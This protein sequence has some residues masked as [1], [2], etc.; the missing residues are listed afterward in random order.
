MGRDIVSQDAIAEPLNVYGLTI[1]RDRN[2]IVTTTSD[3]FG[4]GSGERIDVVDTFPST[5]N[6]EREQ[7]ATDRVSRK[8]VDGRKTTRQ[9][10]RRQSPVRLTS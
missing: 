4:V 3:D 9:A 6:T 1:G 7:V 2:P 8:A 5:P 10:Y